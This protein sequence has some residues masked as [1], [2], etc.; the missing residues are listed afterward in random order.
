M[1]EFHFDENPANHAVNGDFF[2]S[3]LRHIAQPIFPRLDSELIKDAREHNDP[4]VREN[5]V[6]EYVY[7]HE[8]DS[9]PVLLKL[10]QDEADKAVRISLFEE[11]VRLDKGA[12]QQYLERYGTPKDLHPLGIAN[13]AM[14]ANGS[15]PTKTDPKEIFDQTIPLRISLREYVEVE[16]RK[17]MY[18]VFAPIQET[19]VAGQLLACSVVETRTTRIVL[20]KHLKNLHSDGSLHIEVTLFNGRT[21]GDATGTG[22]FSFQTMLKVPFYPSG[23]IGDQS[24]GLIPDANIVVERS[25]CTKPDA[26]L[27][28]RGIPAINNVTGIIRAWGYTRPDKA[29]FDPSGRVDQVAGLFHLGSLIDPRV[30]DY[31]NT[32]TIGTYRGVL[33]PDE[34]G[35]IPLNTNPSYA[36]L[37]GEIDRDRDGKAENPGEQYDI[38]PEVYPLSHYVG[39]GP[40]TQGP[41]LKR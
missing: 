1:Y 29:T 18:H 36:T 9:F 30:R 15:R 12:F 22:N 19:R 26:L 14:E 8:H 40:R 6:Y 32:Y 16:P 5:A 31:I 27:S 11:L 24:E 33:M 37:D 35:K 2:G 39:E 41:P 17:W 10:L 21:A 4:A 38:C 13:Y 3:Y 28:I 7:R 34:D 23:R 25:G 20:A